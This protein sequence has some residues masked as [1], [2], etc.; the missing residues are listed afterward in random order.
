MDELLNIF[1]NAE[2]MWQYINQYAARAGREATRTVLELYYVL[3]S[4]D[5]PIFDKTI[6]VAALAYQLL[7]EDLL[8]R[9]KYGMLI[10]LLDNGLTLGIAYNRVKSR[11][12]PQ[13]S[14]QVVAL[15]DQWFGEE[16]NDLIS[17]ATGNIEVNAP[18]MPIKQQPPLQTVRVSIQN[19]VLNPP[20]QPA[21]TR[22]SV[23]YDDV[24]I[25]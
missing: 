2:Q 17:E 3:K 1:G 20:N 18:Q 8:P 22:A 25:D 16:A 6:I 19:P 7:P 12:T 11:V 9:E 15:L 4:P 23:D 14:R 21:S 10:G 5:T 13:I 24:V